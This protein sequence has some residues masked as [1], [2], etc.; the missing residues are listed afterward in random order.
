MNVTGTV[1]LFQAVYSL[2]K[3]STNP[4]FVPVTSVGGRLSGGLIETPFGNVS[5]GATKAAL[6]WV[7][8]KIHFENPWLSA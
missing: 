7:S 3:K 8:R 6:N 1:V 2:L 4:R 5:Y